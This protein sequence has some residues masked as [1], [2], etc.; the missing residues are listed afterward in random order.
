MH[1]YVHGYSQTEAGRLYD[2]ANAVEKFLHHDSVWPEGSRIL[3]AGCGVGAQT[4][5]IAPKN[6]TSAFTSVDISP[7]SVS[8]AEQLMRSLNVDNVNFMQ[9][10]IFD[11]PFENECF[12]HV[13]VCF[14]LE[15]LHD[16]VRA[17]KELKRVLKPQGTIMAIEGDHGSTYF[18]P[19]SDAARKAINCQTLLQKNSGGDA[20]I[21]RKLY[22]LLDD[23]GFD[24]IRVSPRQI[25]VDDSIPELV[26]GFTKNTF[27]A[28]I[29][30]IAEDAVS[31]QLITY[32][33][34][35]KGIDDLL[36]TAQGG[37]TF[38]YTFF[39]GIASKQAQT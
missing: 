33:E 37:G 14:V 29:E 34:M 7:E 4:R 36:K 30:G 27:T 17:L 6:P 23:A 11:L 28:M 21:G 3:E 1:K 5:V 35:Q 15:H 9:G 20:N 38:C 24:Q 32:D 12:D 8:K 18:H 2:Q 31:N 16:P 22:P 10:D 25:Y 19:D 26:E 39:K 13:F